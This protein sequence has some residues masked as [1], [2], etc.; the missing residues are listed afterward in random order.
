[1]GCAPRTIWCREMKRRMI[2]GQPRDA[3]YVCSERAQIEIQ[4]FLIALDSYPQSFQQDPTISF[5]QHLGR[6]VRN[7]LALQ[8]RSPAN[9]AR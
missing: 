9:G 5:Q 1:M 2:H 6:I 7:N 3:M 4:S 8:A